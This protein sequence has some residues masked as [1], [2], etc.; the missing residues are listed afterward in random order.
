MSFQHTFTYNST[1]DFI[2]QLDG[3]LTKLIGGASMMQPY[4][5]VRARYSHL[6][7]SAFTMRLKRY[8]G[9]YPREMSP[10]GKRTVRLFVTREL[11][12]YLRQL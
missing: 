6:T 11:D 1:A 12:E 9:N 8:K 3:M 4:D 10:T 7:P 5:D 2:T